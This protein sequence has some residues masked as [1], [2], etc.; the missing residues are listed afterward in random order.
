MCSLQIAVVC[1]FPLGRW[2]NKQR[3][4]VRQKGITPAAHALTA[5]A[6]WWNP[7]WGMVWQRAYRHAHTRHRRW[8]HKRRRIWLLLHPHQQNLLAKIDITA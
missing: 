2:L 1:G 8:I 6:P 3:Y 7:P 4:R 5:I